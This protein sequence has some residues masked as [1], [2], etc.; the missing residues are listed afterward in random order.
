[1]AKKL[2]IIDEENKEVIEFDEYMDGSGE[3]LKTDST[4]DCWN[5]VREIPYDSYDYLY[6]IVTHHDKRFILYRCKKMKD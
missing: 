1:M 3:W 5:S 2:K 6:Y 4:S